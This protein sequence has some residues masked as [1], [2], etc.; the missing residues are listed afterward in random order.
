MGRGYRPAGYASPMPGVP[1][2]RYAYLGPAGTF[3]EQALRQLPAARHADLM[4]CTTVG[5]ALEAVRVADADGAVVPMEN[6][7][8]GGV[9]A[10]L[11]ELAT[12]EPL[13]IT[14]ELVVEVQFSLLARPGTEV[15]DIKRV[16]THPHAA[17]QCRRWLATHL[18]DAE[19]VHETSTAHAAALVAGVGSPYQAAI[20]AP[21]AGQT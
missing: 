20:A 16:A 17:A 2:A 7:V 12:G 4:P 5:A 19:V 11:D 9:A 13:M 10:T 21:V 15:A 1:P 3:T 8:E 14:R 18:P 6:S